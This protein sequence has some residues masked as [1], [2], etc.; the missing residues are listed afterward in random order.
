MLERHGT[1]IIAW[2]AKP[3]PEDEHAVANCLK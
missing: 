1:A 2:D 3:D